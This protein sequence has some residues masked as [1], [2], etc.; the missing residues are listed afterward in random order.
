VLEKNDFERIGPV[1][2]LLLSHN[3]WRDFRLVGGQLLRRLF[4]FQR[5]ARD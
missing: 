5:L 1:H 3:E 4:V 2:R